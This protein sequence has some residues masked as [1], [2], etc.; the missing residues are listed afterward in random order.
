MNILHTP[1]SREVLV[2]VFHRHGPRSF[3]PPLGDQRWSEAFSNPLMAPLEEALL[4]QAIQE[5]E[6]DLPVLTD[7]LYAEYAATGI[8][9]RFEKVYFYRR[10]MLARAVMAVLAGGASASDSLIQ[11]FLRKFEAIFDEESWALPA[12]VRDPSGKNRWRID[13][14]SAETA[15]LMAECLSVLG[16]IIPGPLQ[17]RIRDRLRREIRRV[18]LTHPEDET[19]SSLTTKVVI[20]A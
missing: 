6:T 9:I 17:A 20:E 5:E 11:S 19:V 2:E 16:S 18:V 3:L 4:Q 1:V 12:H 8:R 7:E 10:T 14:F 15:N 13:L